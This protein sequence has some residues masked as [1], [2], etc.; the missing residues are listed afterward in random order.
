MTKPLPESRLKIIR[1]LAETAIDGSVASIELREAI[2]EMDRLQAE[3]AT[4]QSEL[5]ARQAACQEIVTI[6]NEHE[7]KP[8]RP[9]PT[10]RI[11]YHVRCLVA[12]KD[13]I[14]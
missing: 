1:W 7:R 6:I 14:G 11:P 9:I 4:V 5:T 10:E 12:S 13:K 8:G 2:G 3:L